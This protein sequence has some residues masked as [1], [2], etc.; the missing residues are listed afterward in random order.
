MCYCAHQPST[1]C[2]AVTPVTLQLFSHYFLSLPFFLRLW[3]LCDIHLLL[4]CY[5]SALRDADVK[6]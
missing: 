2:V 6:R 3:L 4:Q 5:M 1:V